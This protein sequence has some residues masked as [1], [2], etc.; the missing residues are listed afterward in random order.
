M[1]ICKLSETTITVLT[2]AGLG[3]GVP[4]STCANGA[5]LDSATASCEEGVTIMK[6]F[7][8]SSMC[9]HQNRH[10]MCDLPMPYPYMSYHY[11]IVILRRDLQ[12]ESL[13]ACLS[14]PPRPLP[15]YGS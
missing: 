2:V 3:V 7:H 14:S 10:S 12:T 13:I 5:A 15:R 6:G 9:K 8:H 1:C 4:T 11:P